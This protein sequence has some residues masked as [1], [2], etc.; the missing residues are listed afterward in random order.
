MVHMEIQVTQ[1][2]ES[3]AQVLTALSE[4]RIKID[5]SR[6]VKNGKTVYDGLNDIL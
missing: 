1:N 5:D 4:M 3:T 6:F 2:C